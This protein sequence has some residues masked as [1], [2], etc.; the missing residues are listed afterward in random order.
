MSRENF[1]DL[2]AYVAVAR[3][4]SFT[5]GAAQ[6]GISQS[7]LSHTIKALEARL[8]VRLLTRTTR[9]VS[10]TE[11]GEQLLDALGPQLED[12]EAELAALLDSRDKPGGRLR[13]TATE[14]AAQAVLWPCLKHFLPANPDIEVEIV[15]DYGLTD[16]V[17]QR[18]DAGIRFGDQVSREMTAVRV[19]PDQPVA[20]VGTPEYLARQGIPQ[21][22]QD[23]L[24]HNCINLHLPTYGGHYAW[25]LEHEGRELRVRVEGQV[26]VT[27]AHEVLQATLA[28]LGLGYMLEDLALPHLR[29]GALQAVMKDWCPTF[30]GYHLYFP[31]RRQYSRAMSLLVDALR[32]PQHGS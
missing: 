27:Q 23:L 14:H 8:G 10:P 7:A 6:L 13:I 3:A 16:I 26:V 17:A 22:P 28:S 19:G 30:E 21:T 9:S 11:L 31:K 5:R 4:R 15:I 20:I 18:F 1:N 24:N 32:Y 29:S 2:L 12:M 25:D